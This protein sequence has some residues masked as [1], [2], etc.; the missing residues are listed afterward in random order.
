MPQSL[1]PFL[2]ILRAQIGDSL[3]ASDDNARRVPEYSRRLLGLLVQREQALP[4]LQHQAVQ[5][6]NALLDELNA[7]LHGIEGAMVLVP[8]LIHHIRVKPDYRRAEPFIQ[9]AARLL[10][11]RDTARARQLEAKIAQ[12]NCELVKAFNQLIRDQE[13]P[14]AAGTAAPEPLNAEQKQNL[15]AYLRRRF[16]DDAALTLGRI[17]AIL[18][19]GSKQTLIVHL[20]HQ[21]SL[22]DAIVLRVDRSDGVVEST[23]VDE[24]R[25][26]ETV[27][28]AG[29]RAPQPLAMETDRAVLGAPFIVVSRVQGH[30][31]GD[32]MDVFEPSRAFAVGLAQTLARLHGIAPEAGG[33]RLPGAHSRISER[34]DKELAFYERSWRA[35]GEPS[36][37]MEQALAWARRHLDQSE[38]RRA[39]IHCDVGCHNMLGDDGELTAL[40][41]WETAVIGNPA[42][43]LA[44]VRLIAEQMMPWDE[45]LAEYV[46]AG[47]SLPSEAEME[48]YAVFINLF[49]MHFMFVAQAFVSS[50]LSRS[51]I[52]AYASHRVCLNTERLLTDALN[53]AMQRAIAT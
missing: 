52:H 32:W 7:E 51:L 29:V 4:A 50:G 39:V 30:N 41:D 43:D 5:E 20:E 38:G 44:Y 12:S 6:W 16:P 18:G 31:I 1:I 17:T 27:Y 15:Q 46:K 37:M 22:P 10:A 3:V 49:R 53:N 47:G 13:V 21:R 2:D 19:G 11:A 28:Q 8:Q 34:I 25:L 33:D 48:F 26:I 23:V 42:Q 24:Y 35:S 40:L 9:S 36:I 14:V 45:F